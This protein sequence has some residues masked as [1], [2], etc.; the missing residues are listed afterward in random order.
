VLA[1]LKHGKSARRL[2]WEN[3]T[4]I[5]AFI[6]VPGDRRKNSYLYMD[7]DIHDQ[8]RMQ[9]SPSQEELFA[10]DWYVEETK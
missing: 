6:P 2:H 8:T 3:G 9:W 4:Y 10:M 1:A 7:N 5:A